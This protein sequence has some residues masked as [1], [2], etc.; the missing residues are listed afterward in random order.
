MEPILFTDK[1]PKIGLSFD[2]TGNM[3]GPMLLPSLTNDFRDSESPFYSIQN[4]QFI[5]TLKGSME[6]YVGVK[7]LLNFTP[8]ANSIM[9]AFDPFDK[10]IN[11]PVNNPNGYTFDS[12]YV[13]ASFQGIR[14]FFGFRYNLNK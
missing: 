2:Y 3:F 11:D 5:K 4:F 1:V 13:F 7:N 10:N 14:V 6:L 9:R 12:S 8:A